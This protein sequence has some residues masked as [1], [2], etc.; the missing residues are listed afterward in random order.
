[1]SAVFDE[2]VPSV[3]LE[4]TA[5]PL[6]PT[7]VPLGPDAFAARDP[8]MRELC[9]VVSS[10][11]GVAPERGEGGREDGPGLDGAEDSDSDGGDGGFAAAARAPS[12][13]GA[14]QRVPSREGETVRAE[15]GRAMLSR[16]HSTTLH[17]P[18]AS[19]GPSPAGSPT[20]RRGASRAAAL[21]RATGDWGEGPAL[22]RVR[23]LLG[24]VQRAG[25]GQ[26]ML[27][28][29]ARRA[30]VRH[31]SVAPCCCSGRRRRK[32]SRPHFLFPR[33]GCRRCWTCWLHRSPRRRST[34][35]GWR[36]A[37]RS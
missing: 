5:D 3:A 15:L 2:Q 32:R 4:L 36:R 18:G 26:E 8:R 21:P 37:S 7:P 33:A 22:A 30:R 25:G 1:V 13:G 28:R 35:G 24:G 19:P 11:L 16:A 10:A 14:L 6:S 27:D 23:A 9:N 12:A 34:R 17:S 31:L 29:S 20:G